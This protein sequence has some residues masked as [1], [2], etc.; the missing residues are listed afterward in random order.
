MKTYWTIDL[1]EKPVK[2]MKWAVWED[3]DTSTEIIYNSNNELVGFRL[4]ENAEN[5]D[6]NWEVG[7]WK[8]YTIRGEY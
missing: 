1:I 7:E 3:S 8:E 5:Y 6:P 2:G 4:K